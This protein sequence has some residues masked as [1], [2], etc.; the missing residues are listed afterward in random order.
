MLRG[1]CLCGHITYRITQPLTQLIFCHCDFCR[2]ATGTAYSSN[3]LV[4]REHFHLTQGESE[5]T[6]YASSAEKTRYYCQHCHCQLFHIKS[7]A[8]DQVMIKLGTLDHWTQEM[9]QLERQHIYLHP[10]F[11]WL[12]ETHEHTRNHL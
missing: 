2:K 12:E 3:S 11:A 4:S 9:Q 1:S 10:E 8:P 6:S 5:L 7:T